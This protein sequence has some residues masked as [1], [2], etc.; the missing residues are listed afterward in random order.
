MSP[1]G[2]PIRPHPFGV[3]IIQGEEIVNSSAKIQFQVN[4]SIFVREM[5]HYVFACY[6]MFSFA[7]SGIIAKF[8]CFERTWQWQWQ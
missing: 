8:E 5:N 1:P 6:V 3:K 7:T 2:N 4:R